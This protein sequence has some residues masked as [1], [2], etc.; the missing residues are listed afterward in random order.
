[1]PP[2]RLFALLDF[3]HI[4]NDGDGEDHYFQ[5]PDVDIILLHIVVNFLIFKSVQVANLDIILI[6]LLHNIYKMMC[7]ICFISF[8]TLIGHRSQNSVPN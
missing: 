1:M 2:N 3:L 7:F 4:E 6:F 8:S 5:F